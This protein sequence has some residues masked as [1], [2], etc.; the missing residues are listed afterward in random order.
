MIILSDLIW[1][2]LLEEFRWPRRSV[3][4]VAYIDGLNLAGILVAT[5]VILPN[6]DLHPTYF[7]VTGA[8]MSE[9][10][11]HFRRLGMQRIAQVHTHP[12]G[13]VDHS[14]FDDDNAYSQLDGAVSIVLPFHA[15]HHPQLFDCGVHVREPEGWRMLPTEDVP[16]FIRCVPGCLDFRRSQ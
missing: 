3:E 9:A 15:K 16:A 14:S 5:S 1:E 12:G 7:T 10:G 13:R 4:R 8:A 6:A 11:Q 2:A